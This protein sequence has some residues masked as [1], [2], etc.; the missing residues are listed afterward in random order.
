MY[1][2]SDITYSYFIM[3]IVITVLGSFMGTVQFVCLGAFIANTVDP[4]VG[5]TYM[6][7]SVIME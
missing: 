1:P 6:T 2:A 7:V 4:V 3:V 5:G